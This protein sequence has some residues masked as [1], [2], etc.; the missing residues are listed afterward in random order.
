MAAGTVIYG[1][2]GDAVLRIRNT[3]GDSTSR[4]ATG[5]VIYGIFGDAA[6]G[7]GDTHEDSTSRAAKRV[8]LSRNRSLVRRFCRVYSVRW[9]AR[10]SVSR[11]AR[12]F[13]PRRTAKSRH[14]RAPGRPVCVR[15][16][17]SGA[18]ER[19]N[20]G[21]WRSGGAGGGGG[22]GGL[23]REAT[24]AR[25]RQKHL[26]NSHLHLVFEVEIVAVPPPARGRRPAALRPVVEPACRTQPG[27]SGLQICRAFAVRCQGIGVAH[28]IRAP[29]APDRLR[30][31]GPAAK[32]RRAARNLG[33]PG[34]GSAVFVRSGGRPKE[35]RRSHTQRRN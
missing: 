13:L 12:R 32:I 35:E 15:H 22:A 21:Q 3:H 29:R 16:A 17:G 10:S 28:A 23:R 27:R 31:C 9:G 25:I 24:G 14:I 19:K 20:H 18:P 7:I 8:T 26:R 11:A 4:P 6:C 33:D 5:P 34:F 30:F 2:S 1:I